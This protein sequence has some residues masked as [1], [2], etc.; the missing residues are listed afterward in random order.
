VRKGMG[1][2]SWMFKALLGINDQEGSGRRGK[3]HVGV[4]MGVGGQL[5]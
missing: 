2:T 1:L 5:R 3:C 4:M